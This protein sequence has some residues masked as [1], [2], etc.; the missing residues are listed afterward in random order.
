M[1]SWIAGAKINEQRTSTLIRCKR[2]EILS[3]GWVFIKFLKKSLHNS[4]NFG[5]LVRQLKPSI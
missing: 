2:S 5:K 4:V 3:V 1:I